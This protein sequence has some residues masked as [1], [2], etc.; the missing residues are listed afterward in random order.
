[1]DIEELTKAQIVLLTLLVSFVTSI[2]TGIVTVT[3][4]EEAPPELTRTIN[5][6]VER[7]VERVVPSESQGAAAVTTKEVVTV[8]KEEDLITDS[9]GKN[10]ASLVRI[11]ALDAQRERGIFLGLGFFVSKDGV[12]ATDSSLIS[13]ART[14]IVTIDSGDEFRAE[15]VA[16]EKT[17]LLHV[18][19]TVPEGEGPKT[20]TPV[21]FADLSSLKLGQ[22]VISLSGKERTNIAVAVIAGMET[23][24]VV[25]PI[26]NEDQEEGGP[27]E[28]RVTKLSHVETTIEPQ[29]VF[30]G[31]PLVNIF[32][33]VIG[34]HTAELAKETGNVR[35]IPVSLI[36]PT[37]LE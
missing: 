26:A 11:Y 23:E 34:M 35:Y 14:Y 21:T 5:R 22:S 7:T 33:E 37:T 12:I 32:G 6:V 2:A 4:L 30:P 25:V 29:G 36:E 8:V 16:D 9:I 17:A 1:M 24:E 19:Q 3:L 13:I 20:F 31:S 28:R 10:A 27:T 18:R 15:G